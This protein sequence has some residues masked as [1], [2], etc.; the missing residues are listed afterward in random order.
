MEEKLTI[1]VHGQVIGYRYEDESVEQAT[2]RLLLAAEM[3]GNSGH[4]RL[5]LNA[6]DPSLTEI[7]GDGIIRNDA[8][9]DRVFQKSP[10]DLNAKAARLTQQMLRVMRGEWPECESCHTEGTTV[11]MFRCLECK[12]WFHQACLQR[13]FAETK[14][15]ELSRYERALIFAARAHGSQKRKW[16]GEP[17]II[18]PISVANILAEAGLNEDVVIA[19]VLHDTVEDTDATFEQIEAEFG[20]RVVGLVREVTAISKF[21]DGSRAKRKRMDQHHFATACDDAQSIK[22]ADMISNIPSIVEY[23]PAFAKIYLEEKRAL[24]AVLTRAD[25]NLLR[26]AWEVLEAGEKTNLRD[27]T[28]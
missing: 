18:H 28:E 8:P 3:E 19:G 20:L 23:D 10:E 4:A 17:F 14:P 13:H 15:H 27:L 26:R 9:Q 24:L 25:H 12:F 11:S 21:F 5:H 16:S 7:F 1:P 22:C 6:V 2:A